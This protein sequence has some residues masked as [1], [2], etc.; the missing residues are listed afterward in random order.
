M[1]QTMDVPLQFDTYAKNIALKF[2]IFLPHFL[3]IATIYNAKLMKAARLY[4]NQICQKLANENSDIM[5]PLSI[6]LAELKITAKQMNIKTSGTK[7]ELHSRIAI[8]RIL[9]K[10]AGI[11]QKLFRGHFSRKL[12]RMRGYGLKHRNKCVNVSDFC[13]MDDICTI[14]PH[15]FFS[16]TDLD[17]NQTY[18]FHMRSFYKMTKNVAPNVGLINPYTRSLISETVASDFAILSRVFKLDAY[19]SHENLLAIDSQQN[20]I[21][22]RTEQLFFAIDCLGFYTQTVWFLELNVNQ[23]VTM[24]RNLRFIWK[25]LKLS[26]VTKILIDPP[27]G[28]PFRDRFIVTNNT[29][30]MQLQLLNIMGHFVN[31]NAL[32]T[33]Q[34]LGA[35]HVLGALTLVNNNVTSDIS[36]QMRWIYGDF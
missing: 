8:H 18:G 11:I 3:N 36:D 26:R 35:V 7:S 29:Q 22:R 34:Y 2:C 21:I 25:M 33:N 27:H 13:T 30:H 19:K 12:M 14:E 1:C 20:D 31:I 16:Y 28:N 6:K 24:Q 17:T 10:C 4:M 9:T 32:A 15:S 5:S 23:L